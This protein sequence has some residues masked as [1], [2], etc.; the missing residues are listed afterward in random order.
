[1][2]PGTITGILLQARSGSTEAVNQL[3]PL[4]QAE[5][6]RL[7][8]RQLRGQQ[9]GQTLDTAALINETYLRLIDQ[10]RA[11]WVDR[12]H[13]LAYAARAMRSILT[14]AARRRGA[15]KRGAGALHVPLDEAQVPLR[16]TAD[17]ALG[18]NDALERLGQLSDRLARIV[19]CRFFGGMTEEETAAALGIS[20]RTVR[21]D[22]LKARAWLYRE[23]TGEGTA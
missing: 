11:E 14:D 5:L 23:L 4:L 16:E 6:A 8:H 7:A 13:F 12:A 9:P 2:D 17:L 3:F 21:R 10:S 22:W 18:L 15:G 19:E 1:M 20:D